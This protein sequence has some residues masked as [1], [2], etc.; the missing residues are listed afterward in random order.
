MEIS[1]TDFVDFVIRSGTPK[2]TKVREIKNRKKYEPQYDFWKPLREAIIEH[3]RNAVHGQLN[4]GGVLER[5]NDR[6]KVNSYPPCVQ[7][8]NKFLTKR[9]ISWF[10]PPRTIWQSGNLGIRVN[11]ELG[12][13]I[14]GRPYIIKLYFK[15]D[16]LSRGRIEI[17]R[18][19]LSSA[20]ASQVSPQ[21]GFA[22]L[23]L[24][25]AK[26]FS[27][28]EPDNSFAALLQAEANGFETI[29]ASL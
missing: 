20:F 16:P 14:D 3:S 1:L 11:P 26:L 27:S 25:K 12:F 13:N 24:H 23:D 19:L 15:S 29:W 22:V 7:G 10:D 8:F 5:V 18:L 21:T 28:P 9:N 2:V 6:K 4:V 17:I